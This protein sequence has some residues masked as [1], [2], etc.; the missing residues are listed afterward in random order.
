MEI[1]EYWKQ[2]AKINSKTYLIVGAFY[3]LSEL[4]GL[5]LFLINSAFMFKYKKRQRIF[6]LNA[7]SLS[8]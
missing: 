7:S 8:K 2:F 3:G 1:D 5:A 6:V 4:I